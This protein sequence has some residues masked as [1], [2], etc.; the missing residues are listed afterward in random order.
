MPTEEKV[1]AD[2][3]KKYGE[4]TYVTTSNVRNTT[5]YWSYD[6]DGKPIKYSAPNNNCY[7][8][9]QAKSGDPRKCGL[10]LSVEITR[11][12][13]GRGNS[14]LGVTSTLTDWQAVRRNMNNTKELGKK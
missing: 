7:H 1:K 6:L 9:A 4:P 11:R 10:V 14:S 2:I 5:Y 8:L 3:F 12:D 13:K